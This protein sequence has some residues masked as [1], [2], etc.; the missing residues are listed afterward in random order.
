MEAV[1]KLVWAAAEGQAWVVDEEW[2]LV[3]LAAEAGVEERCELVEEAEQCT[4]AVEEERCTLVEVVEQCTLVAV[5]V[6]EGQS[7]LAGVEGEEPCTHVSVEGWSS[8]VAAAVGVVGNVSWPIRRNVRSCNRILPLHF[9]TLPVLLR[10]EVVAY[11][12]PDFW[13]PPGSCQTPTQLHPHQP[14]GARLQR[15]RWQQSLT[16]IGRTLAP[17]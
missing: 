11:G 2:A 9:L 14:Q 7:T 5:V 8:P 15:L 16:A 17:L 12:N 1:L 3:A 10:L 13:S 6:E 4:L